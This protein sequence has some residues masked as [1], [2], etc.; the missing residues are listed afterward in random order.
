MLV[1]ALGVEVLSP[2]T[3]AV[4][5]MN[6]AGKALAYV[7]IVAEGADIRWTDD[8]SETLS[9]TDGTKL[10][11]GIALLYEG[12][13]SSWRCIAV[14]GTPTVRIHKYGTRLRL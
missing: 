9:S 3:T 11:E 7:L 5:K 13:Y 12:D 4:K 6:N 8:P 1:A 2:T 14:S 10:G